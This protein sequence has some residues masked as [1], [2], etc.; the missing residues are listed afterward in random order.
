MW[1]EE[2]RGRYERKGQRYPSDLTDEEWALVEAHLPPARRTDRREI[3]NA[4]L[5]VLSTGCQWRA[6]PKDLLPKSTVHE[7]FHRVALRWDA[8]AHPW[9]PLRRNPQ[10]VRQGG[11]GHHRHR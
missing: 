11:R 6:L 7:L 8:D 4:I 5:Y 1:T 9:C 10:A 2:N 3:L